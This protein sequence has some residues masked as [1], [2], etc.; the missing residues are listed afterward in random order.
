M[1]K[2]DETIWE[3]EKIDADHTIIYTGG[4]LHYRIA[5]VYHPDDEPRGIANVH[6]ITAAPKLL[7]AA[8]AAL[9]LW[10]KHGLGGD[11]NVV[12]REL[13]QRVVAKARGLFDG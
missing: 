5:E 3:C 4:H 2:N 9:D 6:L 1:Q 13:L 12:V 11:D 8:E 10:D 7:R